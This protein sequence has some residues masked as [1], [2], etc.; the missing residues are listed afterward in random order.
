MFSQQDDL[1]FIRSFHPLLN[2]RSGCN[3]VLPYGI[4][5]AFLPIFQ[6]SQAHVCGKVVGEVLFNLGMRPVVCKVKFA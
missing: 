6:G 2:W 3:R 4:S 5:Q 1:V